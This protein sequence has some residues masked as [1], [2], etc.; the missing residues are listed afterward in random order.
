MQRQQRCT[1]Q[2]LHQQK[3]GSQGLHLPIGKSSTEGSGG[4]ND[5]VDARGGSERSDRRDGGRST[6]LRG[7]ISI[8]GGAQSYPHDLAAP[9]HAWRP[10]QRLKRLAVALN[11]DHWKVPRE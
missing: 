11:L 5:Q 1:Q 6:L 9:K 2:G 7:R 3:H 4:Q 8:A 10:Q